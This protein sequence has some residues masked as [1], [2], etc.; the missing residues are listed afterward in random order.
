MSG[1]SI[2]KVGKKIAGNFISFM[3]RAFSNGP[4]LISIVGPER[5]NFVR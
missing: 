5:G 2:G 1:Y 4:E 3:R